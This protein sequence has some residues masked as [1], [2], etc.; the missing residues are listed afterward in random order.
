MQFDGELFAITGAIFS[1]LFQALKRPV[2]KNKRTLP[3]E[4]YLFVIMMLGPIIGILIGV[5]RSGDIVDWNQNAMMG[6]VAG[7]MAAGLYSGV[8]TVVKAQLASEP[9]PLQP[10]TAA[11]QE[12]RRI[13]P[14]T[15]VT[16]DSE[17]I[18]TVT[19]TRRKRAAP[20]PV[21]ERKTT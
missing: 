1:G 14:D 15:V 3:Q 18:V 20:K 7:L 11:A 9:L 6:L 12:A 17:P 5:L 10:D 21:D 16:T 4:Y 2:G 8:S 13:G 19:T